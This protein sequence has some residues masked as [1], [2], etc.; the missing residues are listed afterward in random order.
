M[1]RYATVCGWTLARGHARSGDR[2]AIAR[3]LGKSD[4]F[5]NAIADFG[6]RYADQAERDYQAFM[7]AAEAGRIQLDT[8]VNK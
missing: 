4:V 6:M 7:A 2:V 8:S 1:H 5:D 3:Y